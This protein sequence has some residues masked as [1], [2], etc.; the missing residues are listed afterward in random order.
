M[1]KFSKICNRG[2]GLLV[3]ILDYEKVIDEYGEGGY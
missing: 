2:G 3:G 1:V